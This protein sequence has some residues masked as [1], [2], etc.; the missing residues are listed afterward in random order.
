MPSV[1]GFRIDKDYEFEGP[2]G[3]ASPLDLLGGRPQ[4]IVRQLHVPPPPR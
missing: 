3:K 4:L 1:A 2:D